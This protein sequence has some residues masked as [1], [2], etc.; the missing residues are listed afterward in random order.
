MACL[1]TP[2]K[3]KRGGLA[4]WALRVRVIILVYSG[5]GTEVRSRDPTSSPQRRGTRSRQSRGSWVDAA[6]VKTLAL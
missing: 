2:D 3:T 5:I 1:K 4:A 6:C